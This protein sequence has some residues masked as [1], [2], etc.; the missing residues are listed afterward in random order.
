MIG[1]PCYDGKVDCLYADSLVNTLKM[2]SGVNIC[3]VY[4]PYD[5]LIQRS[6]NDLMRIAVESQVDDLIFIDSDQAWKPEWIFRLL[7]HPVDV[8][9][10]AVRKKSDT[11]QYNVRSVQFPI[12]VDPSTGLL[13]VDGVGTGM[14]RLSK[15]ALRS[16]WFAAP[17]YEDGGNK[18]R[19]AFDVRVIDG[20]L[21]SEDTVF[22]ETLKANGFR[23]HV[24]PSITCSHVGN[25]TWRG[26]FASYLKRLA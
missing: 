20:K 14:L 19:L 7:A 8:V 26:D 9:G 5:A 17:E 18:S 3:P 22:C 6:R 24:D 15:L 13:I 2:A 12:P 23:I 11:E 21:Y 4:M 10:G 25:K 16:V 1:T